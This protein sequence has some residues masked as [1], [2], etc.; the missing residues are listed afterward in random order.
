MR[1]EAPV[2]LTSPSM[3]S[4]VGRVVVVDVDLRT[5][6]VDEP[7]EIADPAL[8]LGIDEDQRIDLVVVDVLH[9]GDIHEI[10]RSSG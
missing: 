3:S 8:L 6:L 4:S 5:A 1:R 7:C 10:E 2:T 9:L